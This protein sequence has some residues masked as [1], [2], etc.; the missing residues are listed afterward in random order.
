M[1]GFIEP[2]QWKSFLEEFSKRNQLR[3]TR[4]EVLGEM[5]DQEEEDHLPLVG[6]S[7]EAKGSAAGSAEVIL[8]GE[9]AA[10]QRHID[11]VIPNVKRIAP[12][13]GISGV[14]DGVAFEDAEGT[15]TLLLFEQPLELPEPARE[16]EGVRT[17]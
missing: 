10:D 15:K 5:G 11:H 14:E 1:A 16:S 8:G 13:I 17:A 4:L 9:T 12:I 3:P 6:I 7:F 2:D